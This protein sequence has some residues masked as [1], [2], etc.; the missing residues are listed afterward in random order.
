MDTDKTSKNAPT[1]NVPAPTIRVA[2]HGVDG[3]KGLLQCWRATDAA[4]VTH[5]VAIYYL[6]ANNNL[7]WCE[8]S[9]TKAGALLRHE[10]IGSTSNDWKLEVS[11]T[12]VIAGRDI[13]INLVG[14][15]PNGAMPYHA[16]GTGVGEP[17]VLAGVWTPL[18]SGGATLLQ[19]PTPPLPPTFADVTTSNPFYAGIEFLAGIGAI[20]GY[21]M[22]D[23]T[24]EFH[25]NAGLTRGQLAKIVYNVARWLNGI[26]DTHTTAGKG[27]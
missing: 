6:T 16:A 9:Q 4:G 13:Q 20:S 1:A 3:D 14:H 8:Y 12:V 18:P 17:L 5:E 7:N 19:W 23:G 26:G 25:P 2:F 11:S 27:K 10:V 22:V 21:R 24:Y 15:H